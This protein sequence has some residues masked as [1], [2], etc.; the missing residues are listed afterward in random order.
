[1]FRVLMGWRTCNFLRF[2]I[3]YVCSVCLIHTH[4]ALP[5]GS[6]PPKYCKTQKREQIRDCSQISLTHLL[7]GGALSLL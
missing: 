4:V 1:M 7:C 3:R 2:V 5:I 6:N